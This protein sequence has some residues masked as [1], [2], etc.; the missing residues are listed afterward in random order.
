[1]SSK[2]RFITI[3]NQW[4]KFKHVSATVSFNLIV[5]YRF[6][7]MPKGCGRKDSKVLE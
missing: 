7:E 3:S 2:R 5:E 1:M 4:L 6:K